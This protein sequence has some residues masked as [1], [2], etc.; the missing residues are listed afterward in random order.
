MWSLVWPARGFNPR[1]KT[2]ETT[3]LTFMRPMLLWYQVISIWLALTI[4][5]HWHNKLGIHDCCRA[6]KRSVDHCLS[7]FI[8][9]I[10]WLIFN[11]NFCSILAISWRA[12]VLSVLQFTT[13]LSR[14]WRFN[15][16]SYCNLIGIYKPGVIAFDV[17]SW[18]GINNIVGY[19]KKKT[20][21]MIK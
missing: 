18:Q 11:A 8:W 16:C 5:I 15:N 2:F 6:G 3:T 4:S 1:S 12:I 19:S 14:R 20:R 21:M 7:F 10:D 17:V 9:L 13:L